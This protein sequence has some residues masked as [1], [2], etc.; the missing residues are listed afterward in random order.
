[1]MDTMLIF[2]EAKEGKARKASLELLSEGKKLA[3]AGRFSVEAVVMGAMTSMVKEQVLPYTGRLIHITD[4]VLN[5]YTAESYAKALATYAKKINAKLV[6]AGATRL[7][8]DFMPRVAVL[9]GS[10]IA[11]DVTAADWSADP[12]KFLRPVYGGRVLSEITF[13]AFPAVITTRPNTFEVSQPDGKQGEF[14]E[15]QIGISKADL[16]TKVLK[17]EESAKGKVDLTEA[18]VVISGGQGMKGPE[19]FKLLE[20]LAETIGGTV[21]ATRSAVDAKWRSHEDQ[22]GKSGKTV[23]PK[24]YIAAGISGA[25]HHIMGMDTSKVILAI[26]KDENAS[27]FKYADYGIVG[28]LF[29]VVPAMTIEFKKK[30]GK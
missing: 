8:R 16:R 6:L 12:M 26:N 7:G 9:L 23:A 28:D 4:E 19:N 3:E 11:S 27:I 15:I 1:M 10:G 13:A 21:G 25:I 2:V 30:L 22:V 17:V 5:V 24:L 20:D 18:E 29:E 14:Q